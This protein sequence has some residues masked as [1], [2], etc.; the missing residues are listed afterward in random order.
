[1]CAINGC[2]GNNAA[3]MDRMVAVTKHRGPDGSRVYTNECVSFGFNRLAIIDLDQRSMQPMQSADER[4]TI[5][6]NG[7]I[8]NYRE[9]KNELAS[10][11]YR[12]ES[13]T[14]VILAS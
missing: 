5:M 12:T 2:T 7:E 3:L 4:Y 9:L 1:M 14:E 6:F 8:Y 10:Y 11:P 13:D